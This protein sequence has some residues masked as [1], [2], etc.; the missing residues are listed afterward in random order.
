M[1]ITASVGASGSNRRDD[2]ALVQFL[3]NDWRER[4]GRTPITEDGL[5][6]PETI[7]A[8]RDF[9]STVTH[10][11]DGRVDPAGRAIGALEQMAAAETIRSVASIL[12]TYLT[13]MEMELDRRGGGP[14][15]FRRT[16]LQLKT[17][18]QTVG[19]T[20]KPI[21]TITAGAVQGGPRL[22]FSVGGSG[23]RVIGSA[24]ALEIVLIIL[25]VILLIILAL[26]A[27][28][29]DIRRRNA[30]VDPKTQHWMENI[31]DE[32]GKKVVELVVQ[33]ND[34]KRRF[35]RCLA[36]LITRAPE[37]AK[38]IGV[39]LQLQAIVDA[40]LAKVVQLATKIGL[41]IHD[42]RPVNPA[43]LSEL[44]NLVNE[45]TQLVPKLESALED[46]LDKCGCR[47]K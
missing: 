35:D 15:A 37:C 27:M 38:A 3:L 44:Q 14:F 26:R 5:V 28:I 39:Y 8:I 41:D 17:E 30:K 22:A 1:L 24:V 4:N 47:D 42:G 40:K 43:E 32:L 13:Q 31:A 23:P 29:E 16:I 9:Q 10:V 25:A 45:L 7:G 18:T 34:I 21:P 33:V 20:I 6:G 46:V 36:K 19:G 12:L 2:V 11:V